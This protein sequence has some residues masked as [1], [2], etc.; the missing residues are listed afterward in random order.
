MVPTA[1][2]EVEKEKKVAKMLHGS[3]RECR[4]QGQAPCGMDGEGKCEGRALCREPASASRRKPRKRPR[5]KL[6]QIG[7][8]AVRR[9]FEEYAQ[10][11][12]AY[13]R[14]GCGGEED[15]QLAV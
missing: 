8:K 4:G 13:I 7:S 5:E 14:E 2:D 6:T 12:D 1:I 11:L 3:R 9:F 15:E 10:N